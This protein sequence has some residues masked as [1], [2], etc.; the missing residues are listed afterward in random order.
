VHIHHSKSHDDPKIQEKFEPKGLVRS[1]H[2]L[3][4]P[5]L[6][7]CAFWFVAMAKG[8]MMDRQFHT[9]QDILG[10]LTEIW[11]GL[12]FEGVQ[13]VFFEWQIPL[14]WVTENGGEYYSEQSKKNRNLLGRHS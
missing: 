4:C 12:T 10:R 14:N 9:I 8:K 6:S 1:S 11:N 7:P 13:S 2:P 3:Y 5:D